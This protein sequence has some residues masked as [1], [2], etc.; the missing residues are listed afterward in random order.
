[1]GSTRAAVIRSSST[2]TANSALAARCKVRLVRL[3]QPARPDQPALLE[4]QEQTALTEPMAQL[5]PL[6]PLAQRA[7]LARRARLGKVSSRA[8]TL[9]WPWERLPRQAIPCLENKRS[10]IGTRTIETHR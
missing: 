8:L 9:N 5:D 3:A 4:R 6:V 7:P 1:M 10:R 2:L